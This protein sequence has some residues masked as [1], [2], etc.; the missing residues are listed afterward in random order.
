[1]QPI[2]G[3]DAVKRAERQGAAIL[4]R[5]REML[6]DRNLADWRLSHME[7]LGG[8]AGYG[9]RANDHRNSREVIMKLVVEHDD[10]RA[11]DL[12]WREQNSAIM[13]MSVGTSIGFGGMPMPITQHFSFLIDKTELDASVTVDGVTRVVKVPTNGGYKPAATVRP[14]VPANPSGAATA[15]VPLVS[16]AWARSGEKGDLFNVAVIA[17][18]PEYLGYIRQAL[19]PAAIADW[20]KHFLP[21]DRAARIDLYEVPGIDALNYVV[22]DSMAGGI[23]KSPRL[24]SGAKGMAQQLLEFPVAVPEAVAAKVK[25]TAKAA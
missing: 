4:E 7:I 16:L 15:S 25:A 23:N 18:Q 8:E 5:T 24:D 13:N 6:R 3:V 10:K 9:A 1:M 22:N 17:R 19:T 2:I 11:A 20:Y 21:K 12:F 14:P